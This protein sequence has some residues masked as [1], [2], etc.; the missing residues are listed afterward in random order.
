MSEKYQNEYDNLIHA[1]EL[2]NK[3]AISNR[4]IML[5]HL[6][7]LEEENKKLREKPDYPEDIPLLIK[8]AVLEEREACAKICDER[9]IYLENT[10]MNILPSFGVLMAVAEAIR[11]RD[12]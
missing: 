8:T 3:S 12:K 7:N 10:A 6:R 11:A 4:R 2:A 5:L 1:S 9:A